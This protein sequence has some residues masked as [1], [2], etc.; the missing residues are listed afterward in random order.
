MVYCLVPRELAPRLHEL[1]RRHFAGAAGVEVLV[2]RRNGERRGSGDRRDGS[3][4]DTAPDERR[5]VRSLAGRRVGERR[6]VLVAVG[7]PELPRRARALADRIA[8]IER[9]EPS[10]RHAEDVDTA[11][12]VM[13]IQ[14]G[15]R[16][17]FAILYMRYFDRVYSYLRLVLRDADEAEDAAQQVFLQALEALPRYEY[18]GQ[19]FRAWLFLIARNHALK[20]LARLGRVDVTDPGELSRQLEASEPDDGEIALDWL[21]DRELLLFVERL[22][23]SQRQV[24]ALRFML[25][26]THAETAELLGRTPNEVRKLQQRAM[27]FL[28]DR[29]AAVGREPARRVPRSG[30]RR[31][32]KQ[33]FVLRERRFALLR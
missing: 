19:P 3:P 32:P 16:D 13:R 30:C 27:T 23:L 17:A 7:A 18:R 15:E 5:R 12:L 2:E 9:I 11:H 1:L 33:V 6:A 4:P 26:L 31:A 20:Q 10:T 24:L 28:R 8:F 21:T 14:G 29:L 22:P 25:D